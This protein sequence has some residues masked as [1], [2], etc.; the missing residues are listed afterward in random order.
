M[1]FGFVNLK[2]S[3]FLD[4]TTRYL[5]IFPKITHNNEIFKNAKYN[6]DFLIPRLKELV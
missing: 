4:L 1:G 6:N 3:K 2:F 5:R